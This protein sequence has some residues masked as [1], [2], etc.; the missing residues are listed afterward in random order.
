M[1]CGFCLITCFYYF[2]PCSL[3]YLFYRS[4]SLL[5]LVRP[6]VILDFKQNFLLFSYDVVLLLILSCPSLIVFFPIPPFANQMQGICAGFP[7]WVFFVL[8]VV[9]VDTL[10]DE[11]APLTIFEKSPWVYSLQDIIVRIISSYSFVQVR[12]TRAMKRRVMM[13]PISIFL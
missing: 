4:G 12:M 6:N 13:M 11:N 1:I 2:I 9:T 8:V 3:L 5:W 10:N 7:Y